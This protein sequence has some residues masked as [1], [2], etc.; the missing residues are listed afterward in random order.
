MNIA[1]RAR[2]VAKR[3]TAKNRLLE[4]LAFQSLAFYM[5]NKK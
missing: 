5:Q 4:R 2:A 1:A 3:T